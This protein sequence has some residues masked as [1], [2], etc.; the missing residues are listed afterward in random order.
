[1]SVNQFKTTVNRKP[2]LVFNIENEPHFKVK[3]PISN[4][5]RWNEGEMKDY[6]ELLTKLQDPPQQQYRS[7]N[8]LWRLNNPKSS[9]EKILACVQKKKDRMKRAE[10]MKCGSAYTLNR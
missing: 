9:Q 3:T 5:K 7:T 4:E 1:M 10:Q 6:R 8:S 2:L